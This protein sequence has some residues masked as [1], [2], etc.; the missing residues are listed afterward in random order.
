[1]NTSIT[2]KTGKSVRTQRRIPAYLVRETIDGVPFYYKGQYLEQE[3]I[4]ADFTA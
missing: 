3:G 1:M 4:N 2:E